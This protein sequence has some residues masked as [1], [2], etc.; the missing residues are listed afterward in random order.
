MILILCGVGEACAARNGW[1]CLAKMGMGVA[2]DGLDG[3]A[4]QIRHDLDGFTNLW[5]FKFAS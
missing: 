3:K 5:L 4:V 2:R 1:A